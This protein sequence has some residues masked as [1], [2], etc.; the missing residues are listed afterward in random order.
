MRFGGIERLF[1]QGSLTTLAKAHV[2]VVGL[3]GVGSWAAESLVRS[4]IGTL[5]LI[6]LDDVCIT[7]VNR[8]VHALEGSIGRSKTSAMAAR[9]ALIN[10]DCVIHVHNCF[11]TT[12]NA[13]DLLNPG[14]DH[15]VD[16][17]D[18]MSDKC[19]LVSECQKRNV[20]LVVSG[21]VGGKRDPSCVQVAELGMATNDP[22]LKRLRRRLR[23]DFGY[24]RDLKQPF[25]CQAVYSTENPMFPWS[26]GRVCA[27]P[28]PNSSL[29]LDCASGFGTAGFLTGTFG[30]AAASEVVRKLLESTPG[31]SHG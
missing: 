16:A 17:I 31:H 2:A 24:S 10:P 25:G 13:Q 4:G 21:G 9:M 12:S 14:Y 8:Q 19:V 18:S 23:Q 15:V 27:E 1:G 20:P 5:T 29:T 28:E 30:F 22:L 11:F 3:G 6:D 26:D 7:N